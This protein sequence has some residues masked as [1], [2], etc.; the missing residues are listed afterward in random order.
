MWIG[1]GMIV[2]L[3]VKVI[4]FGCDL[5]GVVVILLMGIVGLIIGCVIFKFFY[6]EFDIF[7][8]S[9]FG[10]CVGIGGVFIIFMFYKIFGGYWFIEGE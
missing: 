8:I 1:F 3:V 5:G 4:M 6:F 7:F 9:M 2:G 10:F